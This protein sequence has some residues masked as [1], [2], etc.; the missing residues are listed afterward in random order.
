[1][2]RVLFVIFISIVCFF[3]E[4]DVNALYVTKNTLATHEAY[5]TKN[6]Y[7]LSGY[8]GQCTW[9]VWGRM[10]ERNGISLPTNIGNAGQWFSN[11]SKRYKSLELQENSILVVG[12]GNYSSLGHVLYVEEIKG[13]NV[14]LT[15]GNFNGSGTLSGYR[16]TVRKKED[17]IVGKPFYKNF[18]G[19][20]ILGYI[21]VPNQKN[22]Y[23]P[24]RSIQK[25][26]DDFYAFIVPKKYSK[27][28]LASFGSTNGDLVTLENYHLKNKYY[29][30]HFI[31]KKDG[32]Y[33]ITN[34][35]TNLSLDVYATGNENQE[36]VQVWNEDVGD[37]NNWFIYEYNGGSRFVPRS[38]IHDML[39]LDVPNNTPFNGQVLHIYEAL[40]DFNDAQ[41]F[42]IDEIQ[43][44]VLYQTKQKDVGWGSLQKD[45]ISGSTGK[46]IGLDSLRIGL[47][48]PIYSGDIL[49]RA[50][51]QRIGWEANFHKKNEVSGV[52]GL[53]LEAFELKLTGDMAKYYDIYYRSHVQKLGWLSWTCNGAKSGSSGY[54]Y[55]LEAI[56]IVLVRKGMTPPGDTS[57]PYYSKS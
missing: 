11:I 28:A 29:I 13:D 35:K 9:Y 54:G 33:S 22:T 10:Y 37:K 31:R 34:L 15:E 19:G 40:N 8:Y 45:G 47:L 18:S 17:L 16:E 52:E 42:Q 56:Q 49:Y 43:D 36:Y 41:T 48:N 46:G 55:R 57:N 7:T 26:K 23:K 50:H 38:S 51:I 25:L 12:G 39:A 44:Q 3:G 2:K 32:S 6:P 5:T 21:V 27:F 1:M 24:V 4:S 53:R 14:Y 20:N 30:W